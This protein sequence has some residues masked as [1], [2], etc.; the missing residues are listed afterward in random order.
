MANDERILMNLP[1][2]EIYIAV[3]F[4]LIRTKVLR[5]FTEFEEFE[6]IV[7][8]VKIWKWEFRFRL[9]N[10]YHRTFICEKGEKYDG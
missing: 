1:Y 3:P 5:T 9:Y 4:I 8:D 7:L 10:T 2:L 6:Y